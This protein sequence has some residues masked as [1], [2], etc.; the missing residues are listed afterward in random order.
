M[1]GKA[2]FRFDPK[3]KVTREEMANIVY[4]LIND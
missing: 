1:K 4:M 3:G 2:N